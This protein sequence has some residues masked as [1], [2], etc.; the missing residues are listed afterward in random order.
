LY[1]ANLAD[2]FEGMRPYERLRLI[3]TRQ[4][5][6]KDA[7]RVCQA[8]LDLPDREHGQ[9]KEAFRRH[10]RKLGGKAS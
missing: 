4:R 6:Y 5:R 7:I 3:Y 2:S 10:L 9:D 8:Y 1:E